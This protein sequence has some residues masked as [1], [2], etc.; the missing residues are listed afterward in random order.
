M[1]KWR[2]II[3]EGDVYWN[4]A[5]D[6][7]M[8][9]FR[10]RG[11][12]PNTLRLYVFKPSAVTIGYFQR[13]FDAVN[14]DYLS[15]KGIPFTRR[16][17][18]GGS[19]YHDEFGEVTYSVVASI[20]D[21]SRD[22]LESYKIICSGL[23]YAI[24]RLGLSAEFKPINDVVIGGKKVSGSAQT[25][26]K[27]TL[28]QHGT[29]MYNTDIAALANCLRAPKEKLAA[30]GVKSIL[31]RVTTLTRELN[32][33]VSKDE[34]IKA[35]VD[36]FSEALDVDFVV[37]KPTSGELELASRLVDKYKSREWVFK[38]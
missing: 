2:L 16:I 6:E 22:V 15:S 4:M 34:V 36:G 18:G 5:F 33:V 17:T 28:L 8:L 9:L 11:L 10:E 20:D 14:L 27:N 19:V 29:L 38:R 35:L 32:R 13:V 31:E 1:A 7:A 23:V 26:K 3:N 12:V 21:I 25:R 24:K 37:E 30:H